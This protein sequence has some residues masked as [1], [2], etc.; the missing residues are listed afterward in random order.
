MRNSLVS[1]TTFFS[2]ALAAAGPLSAR[3]PRLSAQ[4]PRPDTAATP[5]AAVNQ[6]PKKP[7]PKKPD[8]KKP[9]ANKPVVSVTAMREGVRKSL[10]LIER[11][12]A[13]YRKQRTCFSCHH[14]AVPTFALFEAD[15]RGFAIDRGNLEAQLQRAHE[16]LR[17]GKENYAKGRG[18]GGRAD[19]AGYALWTLEA[20]DFKANDVTEAVAEF[21]LRWQ[22]EDDHWSC[23]S[24]RP[25]SEASDVT[26]SYLAIRGLDVFGT[27]AQQ[28]RIAARREQVIKWMLTTKPVDTEEHVFRLRALSYLDADE[29][30]VT[31]AVQSLTTL[32]RD[33]GGWSQ[34]DELDSDAY[35]T[36]TALVTLH[37]YGHMAAGDASYRRGLQFLLDHQL[38]DGSWRVV[39]RSKP[40]Q[41][42]F[43]S[44][45]PHGKDQFI[46]MA[47]SS[48]ATLA[49]LRGLPEASDRR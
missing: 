20:G 33:D 4:Q 45:F 38:D 19:T 31:A 2:L 1:V 18:Q 29:S 46:S 13:E 22:Q 14:S 26:T 16:H 10:E 44:G 11:S 40:F 24:N 21:L 47:A 23:T 12:T 27:E 30:A 7:D 36:A 32:Q 8:P 25:P 42:Y 37:E 35:A 3:Q 39:S 34:N 28:Q 9:S 15:R 17:R 41:T 43:E 48:W 49:L 5:T 6:D